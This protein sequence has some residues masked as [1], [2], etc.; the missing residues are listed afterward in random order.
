M[1]LSVR[2]VPRCQAK[3]SILNKG[4]SGPLQ[5]MLRDIAVGRSCF[6]P[7]SLKLKRHRA[8]PQHGFCYELL[9]EL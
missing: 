8:Q 6:V 5:S 7:D 2:L 4:N 3:P 9:E 1:P